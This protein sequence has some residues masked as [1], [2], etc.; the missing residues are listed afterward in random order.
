MPAHSSRNPEVLCNS[1]TS[2]LPQPGCLLKEV[3]KSLPLGVNARLCVLLI[4]L[5]RETYRTSAFWLFAHF[6]PDASM[7]SSRGSPPLAAVANFGSAA[8]ARISHLQ[9]LDCPTRQPRSQLTC[10]YLSVCH[11]TNS[12][13]AGTAIMQGGSVIIRAHLPHLA[14]T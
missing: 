14:Q 4:S 3:K 7:T 9:K 5:G 1:S 12:D 8:S 10:M 11:I 13:F 2:H 6:S